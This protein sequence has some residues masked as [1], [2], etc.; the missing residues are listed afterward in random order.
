MRGPP[1]RVLIGSA[2][3][4]GLDIDVVD[5]EG[6]HNDRPDSDERSGVAG[7]ELSSTT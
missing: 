2:D 6:P 5:N 1:R 7:Y 4:A 3:N